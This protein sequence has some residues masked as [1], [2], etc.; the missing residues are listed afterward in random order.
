MAGA[1]QLV[2]LEIGVSSERGGAIGEQGPEVCHLAVVN[3]GA[4][5]P[6]RIYGAVERGERRAVG[7]DQV[8]EF[9]VRVEIGLPEGVGGEEALFE[10]VAHH[11]TAAGSLP[12]RGSLAVLSAGDLSTGEQ[13]TRQLPARQLS[14]G[15]LPTTW[16]AHGAGVEGASGRIAG[17]GEVEVPGDDGED[18]PVKVIEQV[19]VAS[20]AG[21]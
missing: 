7:V 12:T 16:T 18:S 8:V 19:V 9:A 1:A 5:D 2:G 11:E 17:Q 10:G 15:E 3:R 13:S 14:T 20:G 6:G 21:H 4:S